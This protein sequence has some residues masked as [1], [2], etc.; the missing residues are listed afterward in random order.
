MSPI[1]ESIQ[2]SPKGHYLHMFGTF[3]CVTVTSILQVLKEMFISIPQGVPPCKILPYQNMVLLSRDC[4]IIFVML[5][6]L[7]AICPLNYCSD[8]NFRIY[9][10][11]NNSYTY[12]QFKIGEQ[13][14]NFKT[15]TM[16]ATQ[17]ASL[18][19]NMMN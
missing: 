19:L 9:H 15:S 17:N 11:I 2:I 7:Y 1:Q 8:R 12:T 5:G 4:Y 13:I 10:S 18:C 14:R 16:S 6:V 3:N